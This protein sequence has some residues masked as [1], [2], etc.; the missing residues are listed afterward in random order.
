[1]LRYL[2]CLVSDRTR[3]KLK[4]FPGR[5][6]GNKDRCLASG[7]DD[8]ENGGTASSMLPPIYPRCSYPFNTHIDD[9]L[10]GSFVLAANGS[11]ESWLSN[12]ARSPLQHAAILFQFADDRSASQG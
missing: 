7:R 6:L 5:S 12:F 10:A 1:M 8:A 9:Q 11:K 3:F 4:L 2:N